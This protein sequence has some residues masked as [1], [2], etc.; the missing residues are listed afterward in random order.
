MLLNRPPFVVAC[1]RTNPFQQGAGMIDDEDADGLR[2]RPKARRIESEDEDRPRR[3]RREDPDDPYDRGVGEDS[4]GG[5]I[6]YKNPKALIG[7][8]VSIFGFFLPLIG[9]IAA[10]VLGFK[11]LSFAKKNPRAKGTAHA[12]V[13]IVLGILGSLFWGMVLIGII[14]SVA[15]R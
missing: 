8:Y 4:T 3:V 11:G 12:I 1:V 5:L 6:P 9:S 15:M 13:A 14:A 7:Y 10:V 2:S